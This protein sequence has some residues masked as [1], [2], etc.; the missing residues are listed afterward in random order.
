MESPPA[1][2]GLSFHRKFTATLAA[3]AVLEKEIREAVHAFEIRRVRN[4]AAILMRVHELGCGE[5]I[6]ME[7]KSRARQVEAAGDGPSRKTIWRVAN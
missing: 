7:G 3:A 4:G 2:D 5:D 1:P 6:E